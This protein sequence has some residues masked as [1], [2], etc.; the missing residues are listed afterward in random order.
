MLEETMNKK[1]KPSV[2]KAAQDSNVDKGK[3]RRRDRSIDKDDFVKKP[4]ILFNMP[5]PLRALLVQDWEN[6]NK[7]HMNVPL[8]RK[9]HV[10]DIIENYR[11]WRK[12]KNGNQ[13]SL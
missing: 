8:P 10:G 11:R 2:K 6:I 12:E 4:K 9:P 1:N 3:K 13:D 7:S 5:E